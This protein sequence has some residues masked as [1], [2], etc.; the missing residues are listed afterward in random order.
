MGEGSYGGRGDKIPFPALSDKALVGSGTLGVMANTL[1][2]VWVW[3]LD[4]ISILG[5]EHWGQHLQ[6]G[7]GMS[8]GDSHVGAA[9]KKAASVSPEL[10]LGEGLTGSSSLK[11]EAAGCP[12]QIPQP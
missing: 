8:E 5:W 11:A 10:E 2:R 3:V 4:E 6:P 7:T 9:A 1:R 12:L